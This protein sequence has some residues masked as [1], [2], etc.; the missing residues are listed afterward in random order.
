MKT[1][2]KYRN[3][4]QIH[5]TLLL[6]KK[7]AQWMGLGVCALNLSACFMDGTSSWNQPTQDGYYM[8]SMPDNFTNP[9][10]YPETYD[11]SFESYHTNV[12]PKHSEVVVPQ[13]YYHTH[14]FTNTPTP[15]KDEDKRWV[16]NQNP[17]NYTIEVQKGAKPAAIAKTLQQMPKSGRSVEVRSQ[18]GSYI[19]LHGNYSNREAAEEQLNNLPAEV[20]SQ[21]TIK[22]WG[23]VQNEVGNSSY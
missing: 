20:K 22:K 6:I 2:F 23:A 10:V 12:E 11:T 3:Q 5:A 18:T 15:V 8:E 9:E 17:S 21:A 13:T 4:S 1:S 14:N 7:S 16:D 19:G